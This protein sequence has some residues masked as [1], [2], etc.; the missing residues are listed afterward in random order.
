MMMEDVP[1]RMTPSGNDGGS[2]AAAR[3]SQTQQG[4]AATY[5]SHRK[6][7]SRQRTWV[8]L[9]VRLLVL[10][11]G[12]GAF[13]YVQWH[14]MHDGEGLFLELEVTQVKTETSINDI[15]IETI[16]TLTNE[17][18]VLLAA[19]PLP[20]HKPARPLWFGMGQGTTGTHTMYHATCRLNITSVHANAA[21]VDV[22][23]QRDMTPGQIDGIQ[24]HWIALANYKKLRA[25]ASKTTTAESESEEECT[26][27]QTIHYVNKIKEM[28]REL[29]LSDVDGLHDTPYTFMTSYIIQLA[30]ELRQ[31]PPILITSERDILKWSARRAEAH[32]M[33]VVC[34]HY[35]P[36]D[37]DYVY[38]HEQEHDG[39]PTVSSPTK[40]YDAFD[41]NHC[42]DLA[43]QQI[44]RPT[45]FNEVFASYAQL[46]REA[47]RNTTKL[48][49]IRECNRLAIDNYQS[50]V[51]DM[52]KQDQEQEDN[53][54]QFNNNAP[55]LVYAIDMFERDTKV[56]DLDI[57][58][59]IYDTLFQN[60]DVDMDVPHV[61]EDTRE[62]LLHNAKV[63]IRDTKILDRTETG[64]PHK[65]YRKVIQHMNGARSKHYVE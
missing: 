10:S 15:H 31:H 64:K 9:V 16:Q 11:C 42:M 17:E 49:H 5:K 33:T 32:P 46:T 30:T 8:S 57:A 14:A 45:K 29:I 34:R 59:E 28:I 24:A 39:H 27:D 61:T 47:H 52:G 2:L 19:L 63:H 53:N 43:R 62:V 21:C 40:Y 3:H 58:T 56:S 41:L 25:C 55:P 65:F 6:S 1:I 23:R 51:R 35:F 60:T 48:N 22:Q 44:P 18:S 12:C 13:L 36:L 50:M 7:Q 54:S 4:H 37:H 20:T 38:E 26:F